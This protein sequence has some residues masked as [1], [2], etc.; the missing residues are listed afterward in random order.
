MNITKANVGT[1]LTAI[2]A[3]ASTLNKGKVV[4]MGDGFTM[5]RHCIKGENTYNTFV[6]GK[7]IMTFNDSELTDGGTDNEI[8]IL[9]DRLIR[10]YVASIEYLVD[11]LMDEKVMELI[12]DGGTHIGSLVLLTISTEDGRLEV[13]RMFRNNDELMTISDIRGTVPNWNIFRELA[14]RE[15]ITE[16]LEGR[17]TLSE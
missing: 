3:A 4:S 14:K 10:G 17:I 7:V 12:K 11:I 2:I 9:E 8:M 15:T 5:V 6:N 1:Y 13:Y 16:I